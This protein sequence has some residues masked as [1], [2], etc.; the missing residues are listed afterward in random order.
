MENYDVINDVGSSYRDNRSFSGVG[1]E[2]NHAF[3]HEEKHS[4][5]SHTGGNHSGGNHS[6]GTL[7]SG[8]E[9]GIGTNDSAARERD[10]HMELPAL[11]AQHEK[12]KTDYINP[13]TSGT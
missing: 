2:R 11:P 9:S 6:G 12:S 8:Q 5:G 13:S 10:E 4:G 3:A 1:A 7:R